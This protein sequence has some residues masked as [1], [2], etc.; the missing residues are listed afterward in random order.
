M[1]AIL[2]LVHNIM[3]NKLKID[4]CCSYCLLENFSN[5]LL[6]KKILAAPISGYSLAVPSRSWI[7]MVLP[8]SDPVFQV[9]FGLKVK[10]DPTPT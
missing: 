3:K 5:R 6:V 2:L 8:K 7:P 4:L 10:L 9:G 1:S